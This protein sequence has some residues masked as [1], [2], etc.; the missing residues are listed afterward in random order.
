MRIAAI[1]T[2]LGVAVHHIF[3]R[4]LMIAD[5]SRHDTGVIKHLGAG[6]LGILLRKWGLPAFST[7]Q[8][9]CKYF[10]PKSWPVYIE[11]VQRNWKKLV[12]I[13]FITNQDWRKILQNNDG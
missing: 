5:E 1:Q 13:S 9:F 8:L 3:V 4:V 2:S 10:I 7:S 11:S 12:A 6:N